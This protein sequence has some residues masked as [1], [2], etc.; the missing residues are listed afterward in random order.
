[1]SEAETSLRDALEEVRRILARG[2]Q[3]H[4]MDVIDA[5]LAPR[6]EADRRGEA[7]RDLLRRLPLPKSV[8]AELSELTALRALV[9]NLVSTL[10]T[11][12]ER[13][14]LMAGRMRACDRGETSGT[15][16]ELGVLDAL[17]WAKEVRALVDELRALPLPKSKRQ[18][19]FHGCS[20]EQCPGAAEHEA[21]RSKRTRKEKRQ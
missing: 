2:G 10:E 9:P 11:A 6:T 7:Q 13:L 12:A 1:M 8:E 17:G 16:H 4:A 5:A 20:E 18:P 15:G 3:R 14:G 19:A 21:M